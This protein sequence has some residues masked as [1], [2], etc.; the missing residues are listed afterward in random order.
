MKEHE[1]GQAEE[2]AAKQVMEIV[3][4]EKKNGMMGYPRKT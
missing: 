3:C 2:N 1:T 4:G